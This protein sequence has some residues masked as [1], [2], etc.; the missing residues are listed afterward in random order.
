M[1]SD[2]T[3][4][5][6]IKK[7]EV[8]LFVVQYN[9]TFKTRRNLDFGGLRLFRACSRAQG[10]RALPECVAL[11]TCWTEAIPSAGLKVTRKL[12]PA[13]RFGVLPYLL[14]VPEHKILPAVNNYV[15]S[16]RPIFTACLSGY[17]PWPI[18]CY[19]ATFQKTCLG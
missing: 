7:I 10:I 4:Y 15:Y 19:G 17:Q 14:S 3:T 9:D 13:G 18:I 16:S 8:R 11:Y 1:R 5:I 2:S 12:C 6:Q